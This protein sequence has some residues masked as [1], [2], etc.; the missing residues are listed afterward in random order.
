M[1]RE[2]SEIVGV[3]ELVILE[4]GH[5]VSELRQLYWYLLWRAGFNYCEIGRLGGKSHATVQYG[6]ERIRGL[7]AVK[8]AGVT[9]LYEKVRFLTP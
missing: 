8:D 7:L 2:F 6:V 5:R 9:E 1:I 4:G 3:P